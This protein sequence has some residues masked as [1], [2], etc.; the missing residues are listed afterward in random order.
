VIATRK[1]KWWST[2]RIDRRLSSDRVE[3]EPEIASF[4]PEE[5]FICGLLIIWRLKEELLFK[6]LTRI[7]E[8]L[9][10]TWQSEGG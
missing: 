4:C 6:K 5:N 2:K 10:G 9:R 8:S 7:T 1:N 3:M